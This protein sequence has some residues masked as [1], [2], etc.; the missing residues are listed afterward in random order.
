MSEEELITLATLL[1]LKGQ[2]KGRKYVTLLLMYG[3]LVYGPATQIWW[4]R[5]GSPGVTIDLMEL[6]TDPRCTLSADD[7]RRAIECLPT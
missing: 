6:M 1:G 4:T 3:N 2:R 5:V 7:V